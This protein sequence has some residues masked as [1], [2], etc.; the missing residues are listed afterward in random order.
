MKK[1]KFFINETPY[2]NTPGYYELEN[3]KINSI[4]EDNILRIPQ[5]KIEKKTCVELNDTLDPF[6]YS[7]MYND[8][9]GD[10]NKQYST[11][12]HNKNLG[13][14]RG[15]GNLEI[16]DEIR[17]GEF[18]KDELKDF[19]KEKEEEN[20]LD[21]HYQILSR[22]FQDP[23]H[24]VPPFPRGGENTRKNITIQYDMNNEIISNDGRIKTI[25]FDYS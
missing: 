10:D 8:T 9:C 20:L 13:A 24:I 4:N 7:V 22:N 11:Y 17:K 21:F 2:D 14:G 25:E 18:T 3:S 5:Q 19:K 6:D 15:F 1:Q 12:Y 16:S 23:E